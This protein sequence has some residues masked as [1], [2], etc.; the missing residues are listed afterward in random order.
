MAWNTVQ[1]YINDPKGFEATHQ[2]FKAAQEYDTAHELDAYIRELEAIVQAAQR[3]VDAVY[4]DKVTHGYDELV[5]LEH[6]LERLRRK[7]E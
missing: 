2:R 3:V 7:D 5:D 1:D 4:L 6:L